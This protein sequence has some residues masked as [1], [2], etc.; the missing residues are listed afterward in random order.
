MNGLWEKIKLIK[1]TLGMA[2]LFSII[3][4]PYSAFAHIHVSN[5]ACGIELE[6]HADCNISYH[7]HNINIYNNYNNKDSINLHLVKQESFERS[8]PSFINTQYYHKLLHINSHTF[9]VR[10][11]DVIILSE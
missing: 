9:V 1:I 3:L 7:N 10:H 4:C 6:C 11:L 8:F 5:N 2:V